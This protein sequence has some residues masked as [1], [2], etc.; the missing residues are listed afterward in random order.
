MIRKSQL[1]IIFLSEM[2]SRSQTSKDILNKLSFYLLVQ[3]SPFGSKGGILLAWRC[4]V[5]LE[6][7]VF[8]INNISAWIYFDPPSQPC[9]LSCVYGPLYKKNKFGFWESLLEVGNNFEDPWLC[10]GDFNAILDHCD[11]CGVT[12]KAPLMM[13]SA[14]LSIILAWF[15]WGLLETLI[16]GP[17]IGKVVII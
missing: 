12:F 2:K 10:M 11:K 5:D 17:I 7:F 9:F 13:S 3:V 6:C 15:I 1:G 4:G 8:N 16:L 14:P